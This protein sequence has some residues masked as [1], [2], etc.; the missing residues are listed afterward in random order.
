[1]TN[2]FKD[3]TGSYTRAGN[4]CFDFIQ[5]R[6]SDAYSIALSAHDCDELD[7]LSLMRDACIDLIESM[8]ANVRDY[9]NTE[10][11]MMRRAGYS[12]SME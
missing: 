11:R 2:P 1:M 6:L 7:V 3:E 5:G 9:R 12:Q 10:K 8:E 4:L